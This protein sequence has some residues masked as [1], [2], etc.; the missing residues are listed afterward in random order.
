MKALSFLA[1]VALAS[2]AYAGP[3]VTGS[4][5]FTGSEGEYKNREVLGRVGFDGQVGKLTPYIEVGGGVNN[6]ESGDGQ[7]LIIVE[8][9]TGVQ[10]TEKLEVS[11]LYEHKK[12][13]DA[14]DPE[15]K[16]ALGTKYRF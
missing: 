15:W 11:G 5:E 8:V 10:V 3:Y 6:P 14:N 12:Y 7:K 4:A 2:P 13:E 9:G 1:L 16:V